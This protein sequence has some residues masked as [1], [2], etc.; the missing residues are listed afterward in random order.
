MKV[1][2]F[3]KASQSSEA[4]VMPSQQLL[5]DMGQY[6]EQLF[7]AGIMKD[8]AGLHPS[9]KAVRVRFSGTQRT[10]IDGPF[11]ETKE[12]VAG[13][14]LWEVKSMDEAIE[15]LKKCPNPMPEESEIEIRPVFEADDFG[16]EFTPELREKEDNLEATLSIQKATAQSYLFFSGRCEEA[17]E[18]YK[19]ALNAKILMVMR[20]SESPDPT[21]PGMLAPGFENKIMHCSFQV[22]GTTI[23]ASDGCDP[24]SRF[25]GFRLALSVP[26]EA[27]ADRV[28][29]A[30]SDG[31]KIDMPLV[32]TFWSP[33]YGMVTDKFGV[34]WMV[35]VPGPS[36]S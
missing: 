9:S 20:F 21:P 30:L 23:M 10:I 22:G 29:N 24:Q 33:R 19:T 26:T 27:I 28:F 18:F 32:K 11:A 8:G 5:A 17:L 36:Q 7:R 1:V 2:V 34:G 12:L 31:G 16:E 6:N 3:V 15:W 14:W 35:M 13:Y 25:D 4:G